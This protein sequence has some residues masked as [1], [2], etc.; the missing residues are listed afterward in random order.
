MAQT[1][2]LTSVLKMIDF[3][4]R[5]SLSAAT[6]ITKP[7]DLRAA[8]TNS[9]LTEVVT[10]IILGMAV[11]FGGAGTIDIEVLHSDDVSFGW[12]RVGTIAQASAADGANFYHS[13]FYN[14]KRYVRLQI[15]VT[16]VVAAIC[17][18]GAGDHGLRE[19]VVQTGTQ[20]VY[21][22]A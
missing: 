7:V 11:E 14:L 17:I 9:D 10:R 22:A 6:H 16:G 15:T 13:E 5:G 18:I 4:L 20:L 12:V 3:L 19:P 8:I 2:D 1:R 21:T